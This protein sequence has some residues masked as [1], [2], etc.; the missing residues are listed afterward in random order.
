MNTMNRR[1]FLNVYVD[2]FSSDEQGDIIPLT[3]V[4]KAFA[5]EIFQGIRTE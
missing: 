1:D 5:L 4:D 2:Q 3:D